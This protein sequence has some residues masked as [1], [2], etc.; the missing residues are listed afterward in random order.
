MTWLMLMRVCWTIVCSVG[1]LF[2]MHDEVSVSMVVVY[3]T[4]ST[5]GNVMTHFFTDYAYEIDT[6][7]DMKKI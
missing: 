2:F 3:F 4:H 5:L 6:K 7:Y 1:I